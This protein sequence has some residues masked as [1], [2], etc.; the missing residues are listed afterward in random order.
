MPTSR[1]HTA[2]ALALGAV[3]LLACSDPPTSP[4]RDGP[5]TLSVTPFGAPLSSP[6]WQQRARGLLVGPWQRIHQFADPCR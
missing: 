3:A 5:S 6:Q 2:A 4:D 1:I